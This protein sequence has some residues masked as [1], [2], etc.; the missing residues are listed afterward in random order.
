MLTLLPHYNKYVS[1]FN[2]SFFSPVPEYDD[3]GKNG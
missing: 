3:E 2:G 1:E